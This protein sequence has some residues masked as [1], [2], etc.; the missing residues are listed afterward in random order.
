MFD[1]ARLVG[2]SHQTVSRVVN[3]A[4]GV[5]PE[6]EQRVLDAIEQL[7]YKRNLAARALVTQ[8]SQTI[9]VVLVNGHLY[10]P[11]STLLGIER[12]ARELGFW[13]SVAS[14]ASN[15]PAEMADAIEHFRGQG[16]DGLVVIA[17][18]RESLQ[19]CMRVASKLPLVAVTSGSVSEPSAVSVAI[20]QVAGAK[21]AVGHLLELGH[22]AIAHLAG[23]L[24]EF[25]AQARMAAWAECLAEVGAPPG[26]LAIGN[27]QSVPGYEQ[28]TRLLSGEHRPTAVFSANDLMALGVLRAAHDLGLRVPEDLSVVGFDN[29]PGSDQ[30]IPPLTT[31]R[32]DFALLGEATVKALIDVTAGQETVDRQIEPTLVT[33]AS[34]AAI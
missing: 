20:D 22:T 16:V 18:T 15:Q 6:T 11:S 21:A 34:T 4:G 32:Q 3:R 31:V 13:V 30:L 33:R 17:P 10:G 29:M 9:G 25:E 7:G 5:A 12:Y 27:W 14:L 1:V 26:P 19:A 24:E 23:P 8:K 28:A 2:V